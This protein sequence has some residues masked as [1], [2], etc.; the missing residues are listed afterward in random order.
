M[1][2]STNFVFVFLNSSLSEYLLSQGTIDTD[3]MSNGGSTAV[4]LA[5]YRNATPE[6]I[7]KIVDKSDVQTVNKRDGVHGGGY[8]PIMTAVSEGHTNVVRLLARMEMVYW[9]KKELVRVV[10]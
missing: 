1:E 3:I 9:D 8:T 10:R 7:M 6:L 4:H 2:F 5:C